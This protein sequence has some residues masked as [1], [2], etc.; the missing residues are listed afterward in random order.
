[1]LCIAPTQ[2]SRFR[3]QGHS[4][5]PGFFWPPLFPLS[6]WSPSN[7]YCR[8][9]VLVHSG[10][11]SEPLQLVQCWAP[12]CDTLVFIGDLFWPKDAIYLSEASTVHWSFSTTYQVSEPYSR[13]DLTF[14]YVKSVCCCGSFTHFP[15]RP[16]PL[17]WFQIN[18]HSRFKRI[19]L[20]TTNQSLKYESNCIRA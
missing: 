17:P 5:P 1:M 13:A 20:K 19:K 8:D 2:I 14:H 3:F 4:S 7:D 10:D 6:S 18:N 12:H 16:K 9:A 15:S 11:M